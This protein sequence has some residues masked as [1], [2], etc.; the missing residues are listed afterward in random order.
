VFADSRKEKTVRGAIKSE[1][2]RLLTKDAVVICDGL[3]YIKGAKRLE[4]IF[5]LPS[6]P[7]I[8]RPIPR[9]NSN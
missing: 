8:S 6:L 4:E 7:R 5:W 1:T 9:R 2:I 3:N